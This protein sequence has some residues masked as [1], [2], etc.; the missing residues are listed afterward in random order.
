[1]PENTVPKAAEAGSGGLILSAVQISI[2]FIPSFF[3]LDFLSLA[4][5]GSTANVILYT[6]PLFT[7]LC[8]CIAVIS[9]SPKTAALK[10]LLSLPFSAVMQIHLANSQ[11]SLRSLNMMIPDYG[12]PSAGGGFAGFIL[13]CV[14]AASQLFFLLSGTLVS[15]AAKNAA[16]RKITSA[17]KTAILAVCNTDSPDRSF[18]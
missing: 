12:K 14:M 17:A 13:L 7:G 5:E 10:W 16:S 2:L 9:G 3:L 6:F 11:F 18:P 1:M 4:V 15:A 8:S